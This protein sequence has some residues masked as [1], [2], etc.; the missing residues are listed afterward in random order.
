MSSLDDATNDFH[1]ISR[2]IIKETDNVGIEDGIPYCKTRRFSNNYSSNSKFSYWNV[3]QKPEEKYINKNL[4]RLLE[5]GLQ[6][7]T[8]Q[9]FISK[10]I[11]AEKFKPIYGREFKKLLWD[12]Y[13]NDYIAAEGTNIRSWAGFT[14]QTDVSLMPVGN[15]EYKSS[16]ELNTDLD[17]T[18]YS[19]KERQDIIDYIETINRITDFRYYQQDLVKQSMVGGVAAIFIETYTKDTSVKIGKKKTVKIPKGSPAIIKPLHWSF[20][21]QVRV[22]TASWKFDSVRYTDFEGYTTDGPAFVPGN[23]LVYVTRNDHMITPNNL[24]Y[25]ISDYHSIWKLS[26]IVRQAEEIDLPEIVTSMWSS[27]GVFKFRNMNIDE[28]DEFMASIEP[29]QMRGFNSNVE[30]IPVPLKHDGWFL[31]TLLQNSISHMLM[32][33]RIPEF[34]FA[35]GG[36][37]TSRSDVEIQM[38]VFRDVVLSGDRWSYGRHF[39]SQYY[40]HLLM[41]K[42]GE[43]DP[44]NLPFRVVQNYTPLN[45]EDI[46]A[47]ANSLELLVRRYFIDI[48]EGRQILGMKPYNENI[49]S[50]V[51]PIG[52]LL[53]IPPVEKIKFEQSKELAEEKAKQQQTTMDQFGK[54]QQVPGQ[55]GFQP[56]TERANSATIGTAGAGRT[57]KK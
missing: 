4:K 2:G 10:E 22:D 19:E 32:K 35:F 13:L 47:K 15:K 18:G 6:T 28:I 43:T 34:L 7:K 52:Q 16:D 30:F 9:K 41:L 38:N 31:I 36:K 12:M 50:K 53:D 48:H 46:L 45:F 55:K 1:D 20:L 5:S 54:P 44:K 25:G 3:G 40:N 29:G 26:N 39:D 23:S 49:D 21:D 27:P 37:N 11:E 14:N 51:N 24:F 56:P 57:N 8:V 33:L 17:S 42:T